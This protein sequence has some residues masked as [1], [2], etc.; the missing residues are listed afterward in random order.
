MIKALRLTNFQAHKKIEIQFEQVTTIIGSSDVGKSAIVRALYW[1]CFNKPRGEAFIRDG[2]KQVKVQVK[3]EQGVISRIKGTENVYRFDGHTYKALGADVPEDINALMNVNPINFQC[4]HDAPLWFNESPGQVG[5]ELNAIVD[6]D[7]IDTTLKILSSEDREARSTVSVLT[8]MVTQ[9]REKVKETQGIVS[10]HRELEQVEGKYTR[11]MGIVTRRSSLVELEGKVKQHLHH[12]RTLAD[13]ATEGGL[14]IQ[15]GKVAVSLTEKV[16]KLKNL[17]NQWET[18][19]DQ[20]H[21]LDITV[22][23]ES[24]SACRKLA[25][26]VVTLRDIIQGVTDLNKRIKVLNEVVIFSRE[27]LNEETQGVCPVCQGPLQ[28]V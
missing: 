4:Q 18:L 2:S 20:S 7:V 27:E 13:A 16:V 15:L 5:R 28:S 8:G 26:K 24:V 19:Y 1:L 22:L 11:F 21:K 3:L 14:L 12:S 23:D 25:K 6:L 9:A 10:I 17:V